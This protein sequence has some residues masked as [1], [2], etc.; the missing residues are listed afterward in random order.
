MR[1]WALRKCEWRTFQ[2]EGTV[3]TKVRLSKGTFEK[4]R[5]GQG[6]WSGMD[7]VRVGKGGVRDG[8]SDKITWHLLIHYEIL[9]FYFK[10]SRIWFSQGITCFDLYFKRIILACIGSKEVKETKDKSR[11]QVRKVITLD[12]TRDH[13]DLV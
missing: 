10:W 11:R 8:G 4:W 13:S 6:G 9:G 3:S 1:E 7:E 12:Q 5:E 2:S